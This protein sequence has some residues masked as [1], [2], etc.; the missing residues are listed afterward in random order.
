MIEIQIRRFGEMRMNEPSQ[1]IDIIKILNDTHS[2]TMGYL[3]LV[4][5]FLG[6]HRF[7][8][9]RPWTG[10]L[11]FL[12]GGL[13]GIGWIV[14]IFL[15]PGM[16]DDA[17]VRYSQGKICFNLAWV[18]LTFT[19]FLGFHRLYMGKIITGVIYL[20]TGG[21]MGFGILYDFWTLNE[22]IDEINKG[23]N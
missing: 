18:F 10:T 11:W 6:S 1:N 13:F 15:I 22:Q 3:L 9:G 4:F 16:D 12:S 7:Y 14:D 8:Y 21:L 5:G 23:L 20:V 17:D 19:G 2:K